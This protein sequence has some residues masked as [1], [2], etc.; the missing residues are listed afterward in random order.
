MPPSSS[1][2]VNTE[3]A[4]VSSDQ[5]EVVHIVVGDA[6]ALRGSSE[7]AIVRVVVRPDRSYLVEEVGESLKRNNSHLS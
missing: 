1:T 2:G 3:L 4:L 6:P 7:V 5:T